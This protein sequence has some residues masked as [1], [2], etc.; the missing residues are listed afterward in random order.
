MHPIAMEIYT[1]QQVKSKMYNK[2]EGKHDAIRHGPSFT[3][4]RPP[5]RYLCPF[6]L[7]I[8]QAL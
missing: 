6:P 8:T 7:A 1:T 2:N 5:F 3:S 4:Y